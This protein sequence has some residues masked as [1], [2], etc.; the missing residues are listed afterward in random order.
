MLASY[1]AEY[2][3]GGRTVQ[4]LS[5]DSKGEGRGSCSTR[6][7][8]RRESSSAIWVS[9]IV[10]DQVRALRKRQLIDCYERKVRTGSYWG[11]RSD[12]ANYELV[13]PL[14]VSG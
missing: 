7:T 12:V 1:Y 3:F 8:C 14:P 10:D 4:D 13:D 9:D 2:L 5:D 11:I 6:R